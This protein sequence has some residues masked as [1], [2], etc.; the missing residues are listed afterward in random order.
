MSTSASSTGGR[1]RRRT[2]HRPVLFTSEKF[3]R[4][5]GGMDPAAREEA[6]HASARILLT[7]GRGRDRELAERL[8]SFTD[9][10]GIEMLAELWSHASAHSLPGALWR[11][12]RLRDTVHR[13]PRGVSRAFELGMAEDYRSHVVAGVPDPPGAEE[14]VRTIDEILAGLYTGDLDMAMER[15]A[16]FARVVALGI[17][18]DFARYSRNPAPVTPVATSH[19]IKREAVE[20]HLRMPRQAAQLE[21]D[22]QDLEAVAAQ[23]RAAEASRRDPEE[24]A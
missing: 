7:R 13:S 3:E 21:Q 18:V 17:R 16:A 9:D 23:W 24:I 10:Y 14:V 15:C 1:S 5:E 4:H 22:A 11:M 20:R 6:A 12:Y 19:E 8:V 2:H